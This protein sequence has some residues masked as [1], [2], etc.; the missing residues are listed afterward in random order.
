MYIKNG[1]G[2]EWWPIAKKQNQIHAGW[3]RLPPES[4]VGSGIP[5]IKKLYWRLYPKK[6]NKGRTA[7]LNA[8]LALLDRPSQHVWITIQDGYLWWCTVHDRARSTK[9]DDTSRGHFW[10]D[11]KRRWSNRSLKGKLLSTEDLPG[12]VTKVGG[13][14]GT[15]CK[16]KAWNEVLRIIQDQADPK[17]LK[18]QR[19]RSAYADA[20]QGLIQDLNPYDFEHV[21]D[22]ILN[23][24]GWERLSK[25]G[26]IQEGI[27]LDVENKA[28][29]EHA[30]VQVK[31]E[32]G[33]AVLQKYCDRFQKNRQRYKRMIFAVH[34]PLGELRPPPNP[35]I[36]VWTSDKIAELVVRLGLGERVEQMRG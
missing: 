9:R 21:I 5:E 19:A 7:D 6:T 11:C 30:F 4:I 18:A 25:R 12:I 32:A 14:Q 20:M 33:Q 22:L 35:A 31:S 28:I 3:K 13:F 24:S 27:D 23:R 8:L 1:R 34:S 17:A 15:V 29:G 16:P 36:Q 2:G 10:L 26:G